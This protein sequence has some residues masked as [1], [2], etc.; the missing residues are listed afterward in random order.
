VGLPRRERWKNVIFAAALAGRRR[1]LL[2]I[3]D[4]K[5]LPNDVSSPPNALGEIEARLA[6]GGTSRLHGIYLLAKRQKKRLATYIA[7][8]ETAAESRLIS[9]S[10]HAMVFGFVF[11]LSMRN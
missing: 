7:E 6:S 9:I 10:L 1:T 4:D 5:L 8:T 11:T 3:V 2:E